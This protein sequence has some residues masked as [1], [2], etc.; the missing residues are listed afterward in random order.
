MSIFWLI[1]PS[2]KTYVHILAFSPLSSLLLICIY[3]KSSQHSCAF[4]YPCCHSC[5]P[6]IGS[7]ITWGMNYIM[8]WFFKNFI[9]FI[10]LIVCLRCTFFWLKTLLEKNIFSHN[11]KGNFLKKKAKQNIH[12]WP[13]SL[14]F[15]ILC[16]KQKKCDDMLSSLA[17]TYVC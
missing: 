9:L 1:F 6:T 16:F 2:N 13:F 10:F 8:I 3:S 11:F 5:P 17:K 4:S 12:K 14:L 15:T 7:Y